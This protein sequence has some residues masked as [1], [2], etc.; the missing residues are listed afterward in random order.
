MLAGVRVAL[1]M[2]TSTGGVGQ[3]VRSL[4]R[5]LVAS[6][7][8]V[9]VVAPAATEDLFGFAAL[10]ATFVPVE[11][12]AAPQPF[13]DLRAWFGLTR[14]LRRACAPDVVHAHGLRAGL[15]AGWALPRYA[16]ERRTRY[17]VT[18]HNLV[19]AAGVRASAYALL[20]RRVAHCADITLAASADLAARVRS[21]G[22]RDVRLAPVAAP[23]L[24]APT[25]PAAEVRGELG[26]VGRPLVL[27]IGR[28]HEQKGFDTLIDAAAHWGRRDPPPVVAIAG[29][30]P[31]QTELQ[32]VIDRSGAPVSLLGRRADVADLLSA[33][34][35]VVLPSR[36]EARALVAQE[37]LRAGRPLVATAVG[38]LPDLL[39][40]GAAELVPPGDAAALA[41]AVQRLLDDPAAAAAVAA[42]GR[43][44]AA[45]WPGEDDT[46]NQVVATYAELLGRAQ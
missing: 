42:R 14:Y 27:A 8:L 29:D 35:V 11:I 18:W 13:D 19:L 40:G 21:L 20:E 17:V 12:P 34:D 10:G 3:H 24:A 28:L 26:A 37:A 4:A 43:A 39:G 25:R 31:L 1:V 41:Q 22:G 15:L 6:G 30:G 46:V 44:R 33:A 36:W 32:A 9:T 16:G 45:G 23:P 2:A 38:G 5:G 7:A